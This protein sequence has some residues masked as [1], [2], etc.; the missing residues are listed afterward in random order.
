MG[1]KLH[2]QFR[3]SAASNARSTNK[4]FKK[5]MTQIYYTDV[6]GDKSGIIDYVAVQPMIES[7]YGCTDGC[8][9]VED[10]LPASLLSLFSVALCVRLSG[11]T[12]YLTQY[13]PDLCAR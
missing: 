10:P 8:I 13:V 1:R 6:C 12:F 2:L 9:V 4:Y 5:F 3:M 7:T 11:S